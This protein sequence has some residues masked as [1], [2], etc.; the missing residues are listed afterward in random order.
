MAQNV[1]SFN[2]YGFCK[3][4]LN[5][6]RPHIM[7]K[8]SKPNC[9][10][11]TCS[12]RH[13]KVCRYFRDIGFCKFSE[14]CLFN[15]DGV[16]QESREI[17][18]L[19]IKMRNIDKI[20]AE[21]NKEIESLDKLIKETLD[22]NKVE[23][24]KFDQ[25]VK[26]V[27]NKMEV[28]ESNLSTMKK[29]LLEKDTYI[30]NLENKVTDFERLNEQQSELIAKLV[31]DNDYNMKNIEYMKDKFSNLTQNIPEKSLNNFKCTKCEFETQSEQGLKTHITRK[32]VFNSERNSV[33]LLD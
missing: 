6:R 19:T 29:S 23:S 18:E 26:T 15:H 25:F 9:E 28:F 1:C 20:I 22:N 3:F 12:K 32:Q 4:R 10:I 24:E 14:W 30:T 27:E 13:P 31:K 8:C 16:V 17:N 5:C 11:L 2:K 33:F 7:E 21:K